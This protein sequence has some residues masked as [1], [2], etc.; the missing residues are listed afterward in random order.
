MAKN[1][2]SFLLVP[3]L[4][5]QACRIHS[6]NPLSDIPVNMYVLRID[7]LVGKFCY[8]NVRRTPKNAAGKCAVGQIPDTAER[9][10]VN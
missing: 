2:L 3:L 1:N 6:L 10:A 4:P 5:L 9:V 8:L 7:L